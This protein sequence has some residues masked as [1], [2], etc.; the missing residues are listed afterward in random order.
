MLALG[1]VLRPHGLGGEVLVELWTNR[2]ERMAPGSSMSSGSNQL[3]VESA[4]PQ[5]RQVG[6]ERWLVRFLGVSTREGAESL[7]GLVLAAPPL[8]D[9]EALWV[10]QLVGA[11]VKDTSGRPLGTVV[12]VEANPASDLLV[13]ESEVLI[14]LTFV[15]RV[16]PGLVVVDLPRG[17]LEL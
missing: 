13:L 17:L 16:E 3:V 2:A 4:R 1:R 12:E 14:P 5:R 9:T 15:T 8:T 11:E 7:R 10:H 6:W